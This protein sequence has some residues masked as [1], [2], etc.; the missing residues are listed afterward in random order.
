MN[1]LAAKME[2]AAKAASSHSKQC[3]SWPNILC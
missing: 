1:A 2:V 3:A